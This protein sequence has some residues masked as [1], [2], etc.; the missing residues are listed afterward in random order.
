MI[1]RINAAGVPVVSVDVPSGVNASTGEVPGAA[2]RG[3]ASR[4]RFG[5][6]KVGL[7]V[8]PGP[9]PRRLGRTSPRSGSSPRAHEHALVPASLLAEVPRKRAESDEVPGR[10]GARRRR[11]A[12]A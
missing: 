4:S 5:A 7:A 9:L 8:A 11:L 10:L 3:D 12:R 6:A 1:E 2:V